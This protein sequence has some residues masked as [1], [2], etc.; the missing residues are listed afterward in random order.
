MRKYVGR[1]LAS[2]LIGSGTVIVSLNFAATNMPI[3]HTILVGVTL[4][5]AG[6]VWLAADWFGL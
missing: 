2:I 3:G 1:L 6:V 5:V 4:I